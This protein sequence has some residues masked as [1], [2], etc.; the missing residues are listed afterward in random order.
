M[1]M[2]GYMGHRFLGVYTELLRNQDRQLG[3]LPDQNGNPKVES[4][5]EIQALTREPLGQ[6][7]SVK[8][9]TH[10]R[11]THCH[12]VFTQTLPPGPSCGISPIPMTSKEHQEAS[13][14]LTAGHVV[15]K[16]PTAACLGTTSRELFLQ[17]L[18][19]WAGPL[20]GCARRAEPDVHRPK[21]SSERVLKMKGRLVAQT[22]WPQGV[23][24]THPEPPALL[25]SP[26]SW[27]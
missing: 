25:L 21:S 18:I 5:T 14:A 22:M 15:L 9:G 16:M 20:C 19:G 11:H 12:A 6:R 4:A 27:G 26:R 10:Q 24:E 7:V 8:P 3:A 17:M 23:G 1:H 13:L 2:G